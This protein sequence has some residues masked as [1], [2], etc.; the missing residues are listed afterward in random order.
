[1]QYS[2]TPTRPS[3]A[4]AI[5]LGMFV[6]CIAIHVFRGYIATVASSEALCGH[7]TLETLQVAIPKLDYWCSFADMHEVLRPPGYDVRVLVELWIYFCSAV[8][9]SYVMLLAIAEYRVH[10][11][12]GRR[13]QMPV[14]ANA[15]RQRDASLG[16]QRVFAL[17]VFGS[18]MLGCLTWI[19]V[20]PLPLDYH[21]SVGRQFLMRHWHHG[22]GIVVQFASGVF[23]LPMCT[24]AVIWI[25]FLD[26]EN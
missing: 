21:P 12:F 26:K 14:I 25:A 24:Y 9:V 22:I 8:A 13:R 1:M 20:I 4:G 3:I 2:G 5:M 15:A 19:F 16:S 23:V 11:K 18:L 7:V 17:A 10:L 6:V